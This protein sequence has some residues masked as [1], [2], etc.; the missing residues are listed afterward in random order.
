[1]VGA[2]WV[3][4]GPYAGAAPVRMQEGESYGMMGG[5]GVGEREDG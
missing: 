5:W 2:R 4:L 3:P 1:M